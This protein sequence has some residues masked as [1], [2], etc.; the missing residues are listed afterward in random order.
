[1]TV[2]IA[3]LAQFCRLATTGYRARTDEL[4][5]EYRFESATEIESD[6][7]D[8][9]SRVGFGDGSEIIVRADSLTPINRKAIDWD[10]PDAIERAEQ[11]AAAA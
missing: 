7:H 3:D 4:L 10:A 9:W 1:M 5:H 2:T 6:C 11:I 8:H